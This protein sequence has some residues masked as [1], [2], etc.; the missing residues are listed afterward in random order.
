VALQALYML[1]NPFVHDQA[2][3]F[4]ERLVGSS[5][6]SSGRLGQAYLHALGRLPTAD[7]RQRSE[8]FLE[9]YL[10]SLADEAMPTDRRAVEAWSGLTRALVASNEFLFV[11]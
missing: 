10:G 4:A 1:N 7:E 5:P 11:D 2:R 9:R 6:D 8:R 3:R